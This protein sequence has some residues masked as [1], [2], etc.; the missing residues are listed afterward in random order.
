RALLAAASIAACASAAAAQHPSTTSLPR[1]VGPVKLG[2]PAQAFARL[3]HVIP[4]CAPADGCGPHE[5]R[6]SAFI[7]TMPPG[8]TGLPGMQQ[9]AARFVADTLYA[10]TIRPPGHRLT[11]LRAYYTGLYGPPQREDTTDDGGGRLIWAS[12]TTELVIDYVRNAA[13]NGPP[14]GTVTGVEYVDV[15]LS[16]LAEKDRGDRPWP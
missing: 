9:F 5:A 3:G 16:Q 15:R 14:P 6:A 13:P 11:S 12:K 10:F 2:M 8:T 1:E 4:E 7:D